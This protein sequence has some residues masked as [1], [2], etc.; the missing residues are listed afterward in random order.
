MG[1]LTLGCCS[2]ADKA[3]PHITFTLEGTFGLVLEVVGT[4]WLLG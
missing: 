3:G 1:L 4:D 2:V